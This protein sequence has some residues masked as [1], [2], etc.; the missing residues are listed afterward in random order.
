MQVIAI[1]DAAKTVKDQFYHAID[2]VSRK[3]VEPVIEL[4][5][6]IEKVKLEFESL[7]RPSLRDE[8]STH[9]VHVSSKDSLTKDASPASKRV[10]PVDRKSILTQKL[11]IRSPVTKP[12]IPLGGS[13]ENSPKNMVNDV[14]QVQNGKMDITVVQEGNVSQPSTSDDKKVLEPSEE[15]SPGSACGSDIFLDIDEEPA[16]LA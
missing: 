12:Y 13:S 3:G 10:L 11:V 2:I 4:C 5:D 8:K 15:R 14:M 9:G 6:S 16:K 1:F 7:A